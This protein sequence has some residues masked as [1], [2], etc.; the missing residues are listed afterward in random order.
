VT[1]TGVVNE[2]TLLQPGVG[3]HLMTTPAERTQK[4]GSRLT[5][6][7]LFLVIAAMVLWVLHPLWLPPIGGFLI[8][9]DPLAPSDAVVPLAGGA[10]RLQE[11]AHLTEQHYARWLV[12]TNVFSERTPD[13]TSDY[14]RGLAVKA[15]V[16]Y[17][18]V[19][20]TPRQVTSTYEEAVAVREFVVHYQWEQVIVVTDPYHTRRAELIFRDVLTNTGT[21]LIIRPVEQYTYEADSWWKN[22]RGI[23]ATVLEYIKLLSYILGYRS[24]GAESE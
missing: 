8:V 6:T 1:G 18:Q 4:I 7:L 13:Y 20:I 5:H 15:G 16:R 22:E 21:N 14:R 10:E 12:L 23:Q 9:S 3:H 19:L 17:G 2:H 24:T 11:A